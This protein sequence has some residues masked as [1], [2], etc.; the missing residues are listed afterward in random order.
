LAG[1]CIA[2][3]FAAETPSAA[4]PAEG[5]AYLLADAQRAFYSAR[6]EHT[7]TMT[8]GACLAD[9]LDACELRTAAL[10]FRIKRAMGDGAD[11]KAA[12]QRCTECPALLA[13]FKSE[14]ARGQAAART[15]L[16][17]APQDDETL[18]LLGKLD[19][20]YVWL[21]L[22]TLGHRTGWGEYWEARKSIETVLDRKPDH[23]RARVARAWIDYIVGTKMRPGTRWILGGGNKRRG[24]Q[25]V[26][27]AVTTEG[28]FFARTEALFALWDMQVR[29][30]ELVAAVSTARTLARDFPENE[31]LQRFL[32]QNP[33]PR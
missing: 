4:E 16:M 5:A 28:D 3:F 7:A 27:A 32:Q 14:I 10:L 22:G 19:L 20:N 18:F 26:A 31:E 1:L 21:E 29:E 23:L 33:S 11:R 15:R 12:W 9:D 24:L 25:A 8:N 6:Y 17:A 2:G 30:R 13:E